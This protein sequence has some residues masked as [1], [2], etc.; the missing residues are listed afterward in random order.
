[1]PEL[2]SERRQQ[3]AYLFP[4]N[5]AIN[6]VKMSGTS[7]EFLRIDFFMVSEVIPTFMLLVVKHVLALK[8][9]LYCE[10]VGNSSN[11]CPVVGR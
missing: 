2:G 11:S 5:S 8:S 4:F 9:G 7:L 6:I 1:M 3:K 10:V